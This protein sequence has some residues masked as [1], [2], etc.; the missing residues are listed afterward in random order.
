ME[1][2]ICDDV[3]PEDSGSFA[4][5]EFTEFSSVATRRIA[6]RRAEWVAA[7]GPA[8]LAA[9]T[10]EVYQRIILPRC[11]PAIKQPT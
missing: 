11:Q 4:L 2:R 7:F 10:N 3:C 9:T 8:P 6:A 5:H 1:A